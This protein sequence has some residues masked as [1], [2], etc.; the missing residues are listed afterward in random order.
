MRAVGC[1][2]VSKRGDFE[3]VSPESVSSSS[4]RDEDVSRG[5]KAILVARPEEGCGEVCSTMFGV[6]TG[7]D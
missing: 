1:T 5:T 2:S 3:R 6:T 4:G 7:K